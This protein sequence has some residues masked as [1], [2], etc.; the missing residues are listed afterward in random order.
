MRKDVII[1]NSSGGMT[2]DLFT[3]DETKAHI[4]EHYDIFTD[5]DKL[6]PQLSAENGDANASTHNIR[7][8]AFDGTTIYGLGTIVNS[9][10]ITELCIFKRTDFTSSTWTADS[11]SSIPTGCVPSNLNI[12]DPEFAAFAYYQTTGKLYGVHDGRYIWSVTPGV[13]NTTIDADLTG[14]TNVSNILHHSKDDNLYLGYDNK[15]ASKNGGN[16]WNFTALTLPADYIISSLS[17]SGNYLA[18]GCRPIGGGNSKTFLWGRDSTLAT[19]DETIDWG[20]GN[21]MLLEQ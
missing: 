9:T 13:S 1:K 19:V 4:L 14:Y 12:T 21:L 15:I 10:P 20:D 17:E 2:N 5:P 3:R 16:A 6:R 11:H 7:N 8:F 18:I